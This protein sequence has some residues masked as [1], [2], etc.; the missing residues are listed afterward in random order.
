MDGPQSIIHRAL[1]PLTSKL[2]VFPHIHSAKCV[3][4]AYKCCYCSYNYCKRL[5]PFAHDIKMAILGVN[6]KVSRSTEQI[7]IDGNSI[8][9][10]HQNF[11][12]LF[13]FILNIIFID[14]SLCWAAKLWSCPPRWPFWRHV[15]GG[16]CH[17]Y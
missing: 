17:I 2:Q 5:D 1:Q 10:E 4:K 12:F 8:I 16:L 15:Q 14:Y 6:F 3:G 9:Y 7:N 11:Y 13:Y